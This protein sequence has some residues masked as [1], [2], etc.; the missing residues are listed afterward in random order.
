MAK[1]KLPNLCIDKKTFVEVIT[2]MQKTSKDIGKL[3]DLG[4]DL[5]NFTEPYENIIHHLLQSI[6][7]DEQMGWIDW[8]LYE[9]PAISKGE[10]NKAWKTLSDGTK[11]E[12]CY[13][14]NSLWEEILDIE[15]KNIAE[16]VVSDIN[17]SEYYKEMGRNGEI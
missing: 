1:Q 7:N 16:S 2:N 14:I 12:I 4:L 13:D 5:I 6:F 3:Y 11:V 17:E 9:R 15:R 10:N 8:F